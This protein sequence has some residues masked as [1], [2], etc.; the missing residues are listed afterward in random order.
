LGEGEAARAVEGGRGGAGDID[1]ETRHR[2]R[3]GI[4]PKTSGGA[5]EQRR[6]RR[7]GDI[8]MCGRRGIGFWGGRAGVGAR[9]GW[10]GRGGQGERQT[11]RQR[12]DALPITHQVFVFLSFFLGVEIRLLL[13]QNNPWKRKK[14]HLKINLSKK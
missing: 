5:A 11:H 12:A 14:L 6:Q 7:G 4:D 13:L 8:T 9:R 2:P 10:S 3:G 1:L